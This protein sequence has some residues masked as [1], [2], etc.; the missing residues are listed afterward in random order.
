MLLGEGGVVLLPW[1]PPGA[2]VFLLTDVSPAPTGPEEVS[3][4]G[5]DKLC[6]T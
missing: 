6:V 5:M 3:A 1:Q 2:G 4:G